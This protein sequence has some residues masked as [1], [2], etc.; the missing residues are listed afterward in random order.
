[1]TV[2]K[3]YTRQRKK[4]VI[5]KS[6]RYPLAAQIG[7]GQS[8]SAALQRADTYCGS[9]QR[10]LTLTGNY[11]RHLTKPCRFIFDL[12]RIYPFIFKWYRNLVFGMMRW[13]LFGMTGGTFDYDCPTSSFRK[14]GDLPLIITKIIIIFLIIKNCKSCV[15][16]NENHLKIIPKFYHSGR[17]GHFLWILIDCHK[18]A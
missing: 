6:L 1:M 14:W 7:Y 11:D 5:Y 16:E 15:F 4:Q 2:Q 13:L 10:S 12:W 18:K 8:C 3:A 9:A 17:L